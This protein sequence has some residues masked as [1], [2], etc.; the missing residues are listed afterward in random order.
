MLLKRGIEISSSKPRLNWL[1]KWA[2][3]AVA[4]RKISAFSLQYGKYKIKKIT[5]FNLFRLH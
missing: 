2:I 3:R 5:S 1:R 4:N